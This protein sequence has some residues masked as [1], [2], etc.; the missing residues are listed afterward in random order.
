VH[1]DRPP[2]PDGYSNYGANRAM[3]RSV[4]HGVTS[5][6]RA[7]PANP[8]PFIVLST[9]NAKCGSGGRLRPLLVLVVAVAQRGSSD[10]VKT[11][12]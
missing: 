1:Y 2:A 4:P 9:D 7:T 8:T 5:V 3:N 12:G 11:M 6:L 10:A